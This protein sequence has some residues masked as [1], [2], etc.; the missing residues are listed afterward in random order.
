MG[1]FRHTS[2][3]PEDARG[4]VVAVGNFDGVHRGHQAI[5]AAARAR[6]DE[7]GTVPAVLTFEPHPRQVFKPDT[8]S[9]RLSSLRTKTRVM[10]ELGIAHLFVLHFDHAFAR[11]TAAAFIDEIL[12]RD[13]AARHVVVGAGFRFGHKRAGDVA[14]LRQAGRTHGFGVTALEA[15]ADEQGQVISSS[16]VRQALREGDPREAARLLGRP[17]E[18]EGRVDHGERRGRELGF[19]TANL[20]LDDYLKPAHGIYAVRAGVDEGPA[21]R[22]LDGAGY[23]GRRPTLAGRDELLE[24]HLFSVSP[25]LYG[26]HLRVRLYDFIRGDRA[27]DSLAAMREQIAKDCSAARHVLAAEPPAA[28]EPGRRAGVR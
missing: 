4:T 20:G 6:A 19:P 25:D 17:W 15:V 8:A 12:V 22:W 23:V 7:L 24:V 2:G 5:L 26:Q 3:L 10:Q 13:L 16:S 28:A 21:T 27:F 11:Q 1:V 18:V 14:R 9:F